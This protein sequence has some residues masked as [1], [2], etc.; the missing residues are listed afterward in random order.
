MA[1]YLSFAQNIGAIGERAT[2]AV[3]SAAPPMRPRLLQVA[4]AAVVCWCLFVN[5]YARDVTGALE[6]EMEVDLGIS[7][8]EFQALRT[9]GPASA[10]PPRHRNFRANPQAVA[11]GARAPHR[12]EVAL[13]GDD[14][15][16]LAS[17]VPFCRLYDFRGD[18]FVAIVVEHLAADSRARGS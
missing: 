4:L 15:A 2:M 8:G 10:E 9:G 5:H 7:P 1:E 3:I 18:V 13:P 12:P 14:A 6:R 17:R 11:M 16:S